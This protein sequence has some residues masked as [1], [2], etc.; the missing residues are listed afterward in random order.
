[1]DAARLR[2][3]P[4]LMTAFSFILGVVP[5]LIATGVSY[6]Q[7]QAEGIERLTGAG[8]YYGAA[9]TEGESVRNQDVCIVGGA[10]SAGQAAM[11]F[12]RFARTVT[13]LVR[14]PSLSDRMSRY[15]IDQI[16]EVDNIRVRHGA[17]VLEVQGETRLERLVI[18]S[19]G[20]RDPEAVSVRK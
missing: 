15:L 1:M 11:Y 18:S 19:V 14:G 8:V 20:G 12:S 3:R 16:D 17:E 2:F 7:L 4:I 5:L 13:M 6:R 10:N 9:M